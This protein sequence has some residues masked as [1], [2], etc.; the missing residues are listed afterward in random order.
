MICESGRELQRRLLEATFTIDSAREQRI[1]QVTSA[2][3]IRHGSVEAGHDPGV[4]SVFGPVRAARL[5]YRNRREPTSTRPMPGGRCPMTRTRW[6]CG[7]WRPSTW[8]AA[9]TAGP[10]GHP[11]PDR[12]TLGRA[13]LACLALY[14]A[15]WTGDFYEQRAAG[16]DAALPDSDVL[17]MQADGKGIALRPSTAAA[18]AR[19]PMPPI[20][21]SRRWPRSSRS[22]TSPPPSASRRTSPP[23]RPAAGRTPDRKHA[24]SG[25]GVHHQ[26]HPR[27]DQR[28]V[29]RGRPPR[30]APHPPARV[31]GG[32]EQ[33]QITAISACAGERGLKV[34]VLIDFI[35]VSGYLGKA[36]AALHPA[37]R[38]PPPG[39]PT[40]RSC[41][42]STAAPRP[43]PP[44]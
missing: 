43:S 3:G 22:P 6:G 41:A 29:R 31:P 21:G 19:G 44:P 15:A 32:R 33:Q 9:V 25:I 18:P 30:P 20:P 26:R 34:P 1:G 7:P 4:M 23:R 36:A 24:I 27:H 16:A 35:H 5:A 39:G 37:T 14:L 38:P 17:M 42:C 28:R 13:Q 2:A 40:G 11:G 8:P 12:V 10:G